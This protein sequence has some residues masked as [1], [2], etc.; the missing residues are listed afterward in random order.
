MNIKFQ[1]VGDHRAA[2]GSPEYILW[3]ESLPAFL[4]DIVAEERGLDL[5]AITTKNLAETKE[6]VQDG[7]R[8]ESEHTH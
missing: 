5:A 2:I 8:N 6:S 1:G 4:R 3:L 7:T